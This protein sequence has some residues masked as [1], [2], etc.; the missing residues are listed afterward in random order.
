MHHRRVAHAQ[1]AATRH[2]VAYARPAAE[3]SRSESPTMTRVLRRHA[4]RALCGARR[5]L[6]NRSTA[7]TATTPSVTTTPAVVDALS[8]TDSS[9]PRLAVA[10]QVTSARQVH[11]SVG[12]LSISVCNAL[13]I[14]VRTAFE[15]IS[16][17]ECLMRH[18]S[19]GSPSCHARLLEHTEN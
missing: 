12:V 11:D 13:T 7:D 17:N 18:S 2:R 10:E 1:A 3:Q 5:R 9:C 6:F 16:V 14:S 19:L 8:S 4:A 15:S